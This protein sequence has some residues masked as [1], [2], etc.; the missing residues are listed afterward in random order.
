MNASNWFEIPVADMERAI[1]FYSTVLGAELR[2]DE[3][4]PGVKMAVL[5]SE[6]GVGGALVQGEGYVPSAQGTLVYLNGGDDCGAI[7][8]RVQ[9]AG[10]T[11]LQPKTS[12]GR[13]GFF[14][15]FLDTEGNKVAVHSMA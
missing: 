8:S 4:G 3:P 9:S 14:G 12:L 15:A 7:L 2:K 5:P 11:L 6:D 13:H 1:K 10:G